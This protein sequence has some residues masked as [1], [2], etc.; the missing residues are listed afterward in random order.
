MTKAER[1]K[2]TQAEQAE[3]AMPSY[4]DGLP[5]PEGG[6]GSEPEF[7]PPPAPDEWF[8]T[9][10]LQPTPDMEILVRAS[11]RGPVIRVRF[12]K[13]RAYNQAEMRFMPFLKM[14]YADT[15]LNLNRTF[16]PIEWR[17]VPRTD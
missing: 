10:E 11:K 16:K 12:R 3:R 7:A 1:R 13:T 5:L 17:P 2:P 9:E 15:G 4:E 6:V 8:P 14:V